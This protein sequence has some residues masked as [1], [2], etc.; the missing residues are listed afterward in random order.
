MF[1]KI[2]VKIFEYFTED[3]CLTQV[4]SSEICEIFT[5]I[6]RTSPV[7][8]SVFCKDFAGISYNNSLN[9]TRRLYVAAT[10]S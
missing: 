6:Y 8:A 9:P 10:I 2:V 1:F 3:T 7:V 4:F 5:N